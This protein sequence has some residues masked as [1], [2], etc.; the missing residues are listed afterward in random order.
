MLIGF[1][2][3]LALK[4]LTYCKIKSDAQVFGGGVTLKFP[5]RLEGHHFTNEFAS[6]IKNSYSDIWIIYL[7]NW[8]LVLLI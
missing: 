5:N 8:Q 4:T 3:H 2:F 6:Q 7:I 1:M